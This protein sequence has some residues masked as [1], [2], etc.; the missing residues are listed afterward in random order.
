[1]PRRHPQLVPEPTRVGGR[2][3]PAL[4]LL[5]L[6]AIAQV[7]PATAQAQS[8]ERDTDRI[9][10]T[11][12]QNLTLGS[13]ARAYG[14]GG[15]FLAR[16]DDATAA[17]WNPA[18]LS[19]LRLPEVSLVGAAN[20]FAISRD[21]D[22][23]DTFTGHAVDFAAF[24]WPIG[25]GGTRGAAQLSYQRAITFDGRRDIS[26]YDA[27]TGAL[28]VRDQV[29]SSGGF[30]VVALGAGLRLTR[31]L[32]AGFTINRWLN[33]YEQTL[34]RTLY[35]NPDTR[36]PRRDFFLDFPANG[37][38]ANFGA[39]WSPVESLNL[40]AV[41]KTG[42]RA[43]MN[44]KKS[45]VDPWMF[46]GELQTVTTNS[47]S[48]PMAELEFPAAT[49][50][51]FSWRPYDKFTVSAD[52]TLTRWSKA[53]IFDYFDLPATQPGFDPPPPNSYAERQY[54]T[55]LA[56]PSDDPNDPLRT[57]GQHDKQELRIGAEYVLIEGRFKIPLR[58]GYF[59][60]RQIT[61]DMNGALPR[62]DGF[63]AGAGI[64]LGPVLLDFAYVYEFG[65]YY[66]AD[67]AAGGDDELDGVGAASAV[68][69]P[70]RTAL[71][72]HR[73]FASIIYR[74]SRR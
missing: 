61:P 64:V 47:G 40:G 1:M 19:Y 73:V 13:G 42:F 3:G 72:T 33:G 57:A 68:A 58:A 55:L 67:T 39:T 21:F 51:G 59:N 6:P 74:F 11:G 46:E 15:A 32:R 35:N 30:D 27:A 48:A 71:T 23:S 29:R 44:L 25:L 53:R 50:V 54:P 56:P 43:H 62:F 9:D 28:S 16:A 17:S 8:I 18:G 20:S 31:S 37:W 70:N 38:S 52:L 34:S 4:L 36:R 2:L 26:V 10:I 45:R 60:D 66:L 14:M 7:L 24:T 49:G 63:T 41:Y 22:Y 5:L 12:R 65:S 69:V